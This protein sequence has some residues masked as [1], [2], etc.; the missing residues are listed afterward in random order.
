ML[1]SICRF[2]VLLI[3]CLSG[4]VLATHAVEADDQIEVD[5]ILRSDEL[6]EEQSIWVGFQIQL[7]PGWHIYWKNAGE[8]GYPTTVGWEL[9]KGWKAGTLHF[10][11][12]YLY[13]YEGMTGY[14]L[15]NNFTLLTKLKGP[16]QVD[17]SVDFEVTLDALVCNESTC[18]PYQKSFL[19]NLDQLS[20]SRQNDPQSLIQL[21]KSRLPIQKESL[22]GYATFLSAGG[23]MSLSSPVFDEISPAKLQFFPEN[24]FILV[25]HQDGFSRLSD[26][27]LDPSEV[28]RARW[29]AP[30]EGWGSYLSRVEPSMAYFCAY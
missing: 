25:D 29:T 30:S 24:P 19:F 23:E 16:L 4:A 3:S 20:N 27:S 10:P 28:F 22:S 9:P 18:L 12:P 1:L 14:A 8:S 6:A 21:S 5:L 7:A 13:E 15:E 26:G 2:L 17:K 11:A